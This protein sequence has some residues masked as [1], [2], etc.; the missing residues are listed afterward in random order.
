MNKPKLWV[1][2]GCNGAGKSSFSQAFFDGNVTPF[3]Y[4]KYFLEFYSKLQ[5]SEIRD[6]MAHNQAFEELEIEV[7]E[8][9][10]KKKDFCYEIEPAYRTGRHDSRVT[11]WDDYNVCEIPYDH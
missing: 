11:H 8:A 9:I 4:D 10:L 2:A 1:V 5:Q 7:N 6:Q 3:D